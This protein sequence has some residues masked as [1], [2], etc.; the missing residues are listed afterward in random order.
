MDIIFSYEI[1]IGFLLNIIGDMSKT[2]TCCQHGYSSDGF[3]FLSRLF[4]KEFVA[5]FIVHMLIR[6]V[7]NLK[8]S[9]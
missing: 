4:I 6:Q 8:F 7:R 5:K 2:S 9:K 3:L 1:F